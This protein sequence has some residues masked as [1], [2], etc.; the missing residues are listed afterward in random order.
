MGFS[1]KRGFAERGCRSLLDG[2]EERNDALATQPRGPKGDVATLPTAS[3]LDNL[4]VGGPN[5]MTTE[6]MDRS[7]WL[8]TRLAARLPQHHCSAR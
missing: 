2:N 3:P 1:D 4:G 7:S 8:A 6:A 5:P